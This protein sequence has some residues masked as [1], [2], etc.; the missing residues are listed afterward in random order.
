M[1]LLIDFR[2]PMRTF[3]KV[4]EAVGWLNELGAELTDEGVARA[5]ELFV[6][7]SRPPSR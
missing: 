4:G 7:Q 1:A 5:V 3:R 6:D 2:S